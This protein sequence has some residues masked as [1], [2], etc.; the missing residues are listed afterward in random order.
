M[1]D[2]FNVKL[3]DRAKVR[4]DSSSIYEGLVTAVYIKGLNVK[5]PNV[6][7]QYVKWTNVLHIIDSQQIEK[8]EHTLGTKGVI[9]L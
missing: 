7:T 1:V 2:K 3:H 6:G 5:I 8:D 4:L 9:D